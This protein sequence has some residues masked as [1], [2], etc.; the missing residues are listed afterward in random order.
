[1]KTQRDGLF[2]F[3][4]GALFI[5]T[6]LLAIHGFSSP[7]HGKALRPSQRSSARADRSSDGPTERKRLVQTRRA[8]AAEPAAV[9]R[10]TAPP[11]AEPAIEPDQVGRLLAER[12]R[13]ARDRLA[14]DAGM[15]APAPDHAG[16]EPTGVMSFEQYRRWVKFA[17]A[18]AARDYR[19][20]ERT[21][22]E[23]KPLFDDATLQAFVDAVVDD[24]RAYLTEVIE[25]ECAG[26]E[27]Q[28]VWRKTVYMTLWLAKLDRQAMDLAELEQQAQ[29]A[30]GY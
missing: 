8:K 21:L 3:V 18:L 27:P 20:V 29:L 1:M 6:A 9:R 2:W 17:D 15:G 19:S 10:P 30:C 12:V 13:L 26:M 5:G 4:V 28:S 7:A 23:A 24:Y 11:A 16:S 25:E 22:D 14:V